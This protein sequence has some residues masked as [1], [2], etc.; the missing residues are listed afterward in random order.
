MVSKFK[1]IDEGSDF[2]TIQE[3]PI[4]KMHTDRGFP[5]DA[6]WMTSAVSNHALLRS[7]GYRPTIVV[8]HNRKG[9]TEKEAVGFLD[10]LVI[11]GK[12][13]YADLVRI[14][15][16]IKEKIVQNAFPN[17]SVEV[18]PKSKRILCMALLG[19]T[20]P[21]FPLPQVV[22]ANKEESEW[23]PYNRSNEMDESLKK[24]IYEI[25]GEAVATTVPEALV[26]F[27]GNDGDEENTEVFFDEESGVEYAVPAALAKLLSAGGK[28]AGKVA[29]K[30]GKTA[31]GKTAG[32]AIG[33]VKKHPLKAAAGAGVVGGVLAGT[34]AERLVQRTKHGAGYSI[35]EGTGEVTFDGEP[36]GVVVTYDELAE[37]GM[38]VP[39]IEKRPDAL[40]V[41]KEAK[42]ALKI[43]E[44][45]VGVGSGTD[46]TLVTPVSVPGGPAIIDPLDREDSDQFVL[47]EL[48]AQNYDL[49][50]RL[51]T[52]E[53]ANA[54]I[55]EGRRAEE[56][57]KWLTDQKAS[58]APV[59][60]VAKTVAYMMSQA[61]EAIEEFK[62]LLLA[63]PRVAFERIDDV[64]K[65]EL[66]D[67]NAVQA[68]FVANK[69]TYLS[70]GV[71]EKDLA[72]AKYIRSNRM[73]GEAVVTG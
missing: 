28:V 57:E 46:T 48:E 35:D 20:T 58:G 14:P 24:E 63:Q 4:F 2:F 61:P 52:V 69:D 6:A 71:N 1:I 13:L 18:L 42:P 10:N 34:Q 5:C 54:L 11:K 37:A 47:S 41:V 16:A 72:Y 32:K 70:L 38:E 65:F 44:A 56:Y 29:G 15:K 36:L 17:R 55:T 31:F 67:E 60:D 45:D 39:G 19:G 68:D 40:P 9:G 59:G 25:V 7:G 8:G 62:Q 64:K 22:F 50:Q 43:K 27:L 3:V 21:H 53:T 12:L 23:Y 51:S 30:R 49:H 33:A 26:Q 73:V 66:T